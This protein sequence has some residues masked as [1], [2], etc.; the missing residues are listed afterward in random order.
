MD[1]YTKIKAELDKQ[2]QYGLQLSTNLRQAQ[3]KKTRT[4]SSYRNLI[5]STSSTFG[6]SSLFRVTHFSHCFPSSTVKKKIKVQIDDNNETKKMKEELENMRKNFENKE[7][8]YITQLNLVNKEMEK[9][10]NKI[11]SYEEKIKEIKRKKNIEF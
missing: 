8:S 6:S 10:K 7:N 5:S 11:E 1:K 3:K 2:K 9:L 4:M